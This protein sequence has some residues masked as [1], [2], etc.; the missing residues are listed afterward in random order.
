MA[1][2]G[3]SEA[4]GAIRDELDEI[5][6]EGRSEDIRFGVDA[7]EIEFAVAVT[8]KGGLDGKVK[9]WVIE[10]GA[11]A[12]LEK[13]TTHRVSVTLAPSTKN[14]RLEIGDRRPAPPRR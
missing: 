1:E 14:G 12:S 10:A 5:R 13:T 6:R 7:V 3:L 8:R 4:V 2:I 9:V 11:N